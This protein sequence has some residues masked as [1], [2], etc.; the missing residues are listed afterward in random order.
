MSVGRLQEV[1]VVVLHG[2]SNQLINGSKIC[3]ASA[4]SHKDTIVKVILRVSYI[5]HIK[6]FISQQNITFSY[7]P[8]N[9][10]QAQSPEMKT[11]MID[12]WGSV[13]WWTFPGTI[14]RSAP[15]NH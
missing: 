5:D 2:F 7:V 11:H 15:R 1:V 9:M 8:N 3:N 12:L 14:C 6:T 10:I 13:P 4:I